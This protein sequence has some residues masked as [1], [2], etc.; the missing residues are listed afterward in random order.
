MTLGEERALE[1]IKHCLSYV[2]EDKHSDA[3]HWDAPTHGRPTQRFCQI[4]AEQWK[5][6]SGTPRLDWQENLY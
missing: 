5:Q 1:K 3:P 2:L 6:P 4:T